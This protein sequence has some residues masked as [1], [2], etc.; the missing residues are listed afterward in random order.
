MPQVQGIG[1]QR[2]RR[3]RGDPHRGTEL[4]GHER[5][6]RRRPVPTQRGVAVTDPG[7]A[8][9][10]PGRRTRLRGRRVP[11]APLVGQPQLLPL[12]LPVAPLG[13]RDPGE[14]TGGV[15]VL[16]LD[17]HRA[18]CLHGPTQPEATDNQTRTNR[19]RPQASRAFGGASARV[20]S[21][22]RAARI[23]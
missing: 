20:R 12:H 23:G 17:R 10:A 5:S 4:L 14:H 6:H 8:R 1:H 13:V 16:D 3:L 22:P 15:E 19:V 9:V 21:R 7:Q 2:H 11:H 18:D